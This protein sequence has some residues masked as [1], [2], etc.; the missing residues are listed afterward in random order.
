MATRRPGNGRAGNGSGGEEGGRE[1]RRRGAC[2]FLA[3]AERKEGRA[4]GEGIG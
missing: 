3:A 2:D 1:E 4:R